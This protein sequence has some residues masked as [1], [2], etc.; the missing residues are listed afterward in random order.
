MVQVSMHNDRVR[1]EVE[2]WDKFWALKSQLEI[3]VA[4]IRTVRALRALLTAA[5]NK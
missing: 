1:F 3:P 5:S 4:H 2:G